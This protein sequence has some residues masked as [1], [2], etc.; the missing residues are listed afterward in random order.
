MKAIAITLTLFALAFITPAQAE[1][2][3]FSSGY[4]GYVDP[5]YSSFVATV[6]TGNGLFAAYAPTNY[7]LLPSYGYSAPF[8]G[9][10]FYGGFGGYG[11]SFFPGYNRFFGGYGYGFNRG[12]GGFGYGNGFR[13]GFNHPFVAAAVVVRRR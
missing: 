1:A 2:Q 3:C 13:G 12:F 9:S 10:G 4:A 6:A 8:Y 11:N 7:N 5:G